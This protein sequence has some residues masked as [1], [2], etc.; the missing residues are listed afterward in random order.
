MK[1]LGVHP[2][3]LARSPLRKS[4]YMLSAITREN[5]KLHT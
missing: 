5:M 2:K 3:S 4:P 1:I